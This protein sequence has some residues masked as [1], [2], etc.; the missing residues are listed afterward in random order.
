MGKK[1]INMNETDGTKI[2]WIGSIDFSKLA[3]IIKAIETGIKEN[4]TK[5]VTILIDS[6][7]GSV[8]ASL[9]FYQWI[10]FNRISLTTVGLSMVASSAVTVLLAGS[11]R[12]CFENTTFLVHRMTYPFDGE[13]SE[14]DL[15]EKTTFFRTGNSKVKTLYKKE[16]RLSDDEIERLL[17]KDWIVI[18]A[19]EAIEKGIVHEI[20]ELEPTNS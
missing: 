19:K 20:I 1:E 9:A 4:K 7:G 5:D 8:N 17:S 2:N 11:K 15:E 14:Y 18:T 6:I 3:E 12:I 13:M 16:T 10:K